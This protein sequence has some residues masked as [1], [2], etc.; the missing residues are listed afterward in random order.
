[1]KLPYQIAQKAI[2][3]LKTA[4][5]LVLKENS[6]NGLRNVDVGR[7]LGIGYGHSGK[8]QDH[9]PRVILELLQ[10][11]GMVLQ[12]KKTKR[13]MLKNNKLF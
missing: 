6:E 7:L 3:E 13:W 5:Y 12:D 1:M 11:E 8:H 4:V 10:K 9:V 2:V